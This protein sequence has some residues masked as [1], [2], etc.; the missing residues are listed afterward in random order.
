MRRIIK[1][2]G[3]LLLTILV[4]CI[5]A[6]SAASIILNSSLKDKIIYKVVGE[7]IDGEVKYERLHLSLIKDFPDIYVGL[8]NLSVVYPHDR[9]FEYP[10]EN[11]EGQSDM[12]DTLASVGLFETGIN[13]FELGNEQ[14]IHLRPTHLHN[15]RAFL[16]RYDSTAANWNIV[17]TISTGEDKDTTSS[18][19]DLA[20]F[21]FDEIIVDS[22]CIENPHIIFE[23]NLSSRFAVLDFDDMD[24]HGV[25]GK[26]RDGLRI[27]AAASI[28]ALDIETL[29]AIFLPVDTD[30]EL[31]VQ[32]DC[33]GLLN[34]KEGRL[35]DA[36]ASV[37]IPP[38]KIRFRDIVT[39]GNISL[40]ASATLDSGILNAE[41]PDF[42][43]NMEALKI[44][45][46]GS[47]K[48]ILDGDP[49]CDIDA[50][51][52]ADLEKLSRFLPDSLEYI[53][54][55]GLIDISATGKFRPSQLNLKDFWNCDLKAQIQSDKLNVN[56]SKD[57][58][59]AKLKNFD[60]KVASMKSLAEAGH[61]AVGIQVQSD[62]AAASIGRDIRLLTTSLNAVLQATNSAIVDTLLRMPPML[63]EVKAG[64]IMMKGTDSLMV[65]ALNT[66]NKV[67]IVP[68]VSRSGKRTPK[69]DLDSKTDGI[70]L[71]SNK[72]RVGA[73][74][75]A[76]SFSQTRAMESRIPRRQL[77]DSLRKQF[78]ERFD[79]LSEE[80]FR[81]H[82]IKLNISDAI[83]KWINGWN[84]S[85]SISID[86]SKVLTPLFPLRS[87]VM[88]VRADFDSKALNLNHIEARAG[89]SDVTI[90]GKMH[91]VSNLLNG[92]GLADI[93]LSILSNRINANEILSAIEKSSPDKEMSIDADNININDK[94]I[95]QSIII[96]TLA[97]NIPTSGYSLIVIPANINANVSVNAQEVTY[98]T[99][100]I[101]GLHS[102]IAM[103][104]RCLQIANTEASTIMGSLKLDAFY[105]ARTKKN[106]NAGFG[107]N[108]YDVTADRVIELV[109]KI[110]DL[111]PILKSFKGNLNCE[112][113]ATTQLDTN[114]NFLIPS[115]TG[116]FKI[117]GNDLAIEDMGSLSKLTRRLM[118][119]HPDYADVDSMF[120]MGI[121]SD[122]QLQIFPFILAIDRYT[123]ALAGEQKF[124]TQ[125]DYHASIIRSPLPFK[126]GI[127]IYGKT[128]DKWKYRITRPRFKNERIPVFTS[129]ID[130]MHVNLISSIKDIFGKGVERAI[131]EN[132]Y[133]KDSLEEEVD[134]E[135]AYSESED[136]SFEEEMEL[137][138][139][140]IGLEVEEEA[141][142]LSEEI[143]HMFDN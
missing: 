133:R 27:N 42:D 98:S 105:S 102:D 33:N 82:D 143:E 137:E 7:F 90:F 111:F 94:Q 85:G 125:F 97:D 24:F 121:I 87:S 131:R 53:S 25:A 128:F 120:V 8:E 38:A 96:D 30:A 78:R 76:L 50:R 59:Y 75:V 65:G 81:A 126:I 26:E 113:A 123:L 51:L 52:A 37:S 58:I 63:A 57:D 16:H 124:G 35:P 101:F 130:E 118:F 36:T 62:T 66:Q 41:L 22:L 44:N 23:D 6:I 4:L 15:C 71:K 140:L 89:T 138:S 134:K 91:G 72:I 9:Y 129:A 142:S 108:L 122:N 61:E 19:F 114:M 60:L 47:A 115:L 68:K 112:V 92:R 93:D 117:S 31:S 39:N 1:I 86:S 95:E 127:D 11:I 20:S 135:A 136:L 17:N 3:G 67:S 100:D 107:L 106:I 43:F 69:I 40:D 70:R 21:P 84:P 64:R 28:E 116:A 110:D 139:Y 73:D 55:D 48:D 29:V 109:P 132:A 2:V 54:A 79:F 80:E 56:D 34:L 104:E 119:K 77:P 74:G 49:D 45:A 141:L 99:I 10:T 14:K 12:V 46:N 88:D 32:L 103:K 5:I 13:I 18:G 83:L